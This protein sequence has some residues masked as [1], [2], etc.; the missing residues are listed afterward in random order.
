DHSRLHLGV[1]IVEH[2]PHDPVT[3]EDESEGSRRRN[4]EVV[5]RFNAQELAQAGSKHGAP[6]GP[7][8]VRGGHGTLELKLPD[9]PMLPTHLAQGNGS[10]FTELSRPTSE[11]LATIASRVRVHFGQDFV[12]REG[13]NHLLA[14]ELFIGKAQRARHLPARVYKLGR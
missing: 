11:L 12:P 10:A 6:I 5:H 1:A 13:L 4:L 7:P 14:P 2:V 9:E 3:R 8:R